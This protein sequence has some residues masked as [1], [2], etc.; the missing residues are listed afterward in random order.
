MPAVV[1]PLR[2][3]GGPGSGQPL[4]LVRLTVRRGQHPGM[5]GDQY[6][7]LRAAV[8]RPGGDADLPSRRVRSGGRGR[9]AEPQRGH[10]GAHPGD[11]ASDVSRIGIGIVVLVVVGALLNPPATQPSPI[12]TAAGRARP[13]SC[14]IRDGS[15][16]VT[17]VQAQTLVREYHIRFG[18]AVH[19]GFRLPD[20]G[21][22]IP[23]YLR[24][25]YA[26]TPAQ[27]EADQPGPAAVKTGHRWSLTSVGT[28]PT[29]DH[30]AELS[31][32]VTG[33]AR[34]TDSGW[35]VRVRLLDIAYQP[36]DPV[37][38]EADGRAAGRPEAGVRGLRPGQPAVRRASRFDAD[39]CHPGEPDRGAA[40]VRDHGREPRQTGGAAADRSGASSNSR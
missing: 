23:P 35:E 2:F 39:L 37:T 38:I 26:L 17:L 6:Q 30:Q 21:S 20:D 5:P 24:A 11:G 8:L 29:G 15:Y 10:R 7:L 25:G 28:Y 16:D 4:D 18:G 1:L 34:P 3:V 36:G 13:P 12:R 27:P 31:Y 19:D 9:G 33:A 14:S 40:R 32:R 22:V